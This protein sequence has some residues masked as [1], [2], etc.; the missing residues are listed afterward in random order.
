MAEIL[1][2]RKVRKAKVRNEQATRASENRAKFGQPKH[3]RDKRNAEKIASGRRLDGHRR[4]ITD[5]PD[6]L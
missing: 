3:Q 2:L 1:N 6:K 5:E 4:E